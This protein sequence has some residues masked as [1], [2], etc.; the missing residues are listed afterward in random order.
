MGVPIFSFSQGGHG[1]P[2]F[3]F[4]NFLSVLLHGCPNFLFTSLPHGCPQFWAVLLHG[5]P[6]FLQFSPNFLSG[7]KATANISSNFLLMG[8]PN[9]L[10]GEK[11]TA[12]IS[13]A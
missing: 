10:S 3:L 9:F 12:N 8:V 4:P 11:A 7:E 13:E 5:C 2:N 6:N 1:C